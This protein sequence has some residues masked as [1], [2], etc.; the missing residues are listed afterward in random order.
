MHQ[1][2]GAVM[3]KKLFGLLPLIVSLAFIG[4]V[5]PC[6]LDG[7]GGGSVLSP[8]RDLTGSWAGS[9]MITGNCANPVC[10]WSGGLN[11]PSV[12]MSLVQTGNDV[13]GTVTMNLPTGQVLVPGN[14]CGPLT[15]TSAISG[16]TV[17]SS[18]FTFT[19]IG[20]NFWS[21]NLT[22]DLLQGQISNS[23]S[24]CLNIEGTVS[25]SRQ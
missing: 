7:D 21:L 8:A 10:S 2:K 23:A 12:T 22:T 1:P 4:A 16:G 18:R 24:G 3:R 15:G 5:G 19:D 9:A 6:S 11:P 20:G 14:T 25:L 13:T 17:S